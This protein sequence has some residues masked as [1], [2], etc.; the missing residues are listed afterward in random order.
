M[1]RRCGTRSIVA[2]ALVF[3]AC[4][5]AGAEPEAGA[6]TA[7][8]AHIDV[9]RTVRVLDASGEPVSFGRTGLTSEVEIDV[10]V[11]GAPGVKIEPVFAALIA[12]PGLLIDAGATPVSNTAD[13]GVATL[14]YSISASPVG[15][16]EIEV[17]GFH[18]TYDPDG[19][20]PAGSERL[21][22]EAGPTISVGELAAGVAA[23]DEPS[24]AGGAVEA[25]PSRAWVW[26]ALAALVVAVVV[27]LTI[28]GVVLLIVRRP[29]PAAAQAP[30][31]APDTVALERLDALERSGLIDRGEYERLTGE[32]SD[33]A[34]WYIGERFG[35]RAPE[36]TTQEFLS[37]ARR[38]ADL[39]GEA[40]TLSSFLRSCDE[41]KFAKATGSRE[42]A[43]SALGLVRSFVVRTRRAFGG[44]G[45]GTPPGAAQGAAQGE[46]RPDQPSAATATGGRA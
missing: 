21:F 27:G 4:G 2:A 38:N 23:A 13:S 39:G 43:E 15:V 40:D 30:R 24:E 22:V 1:L 37:A 28:V 6:T 3:G 31:R 33:I 45:E 41:L 20:G 35:L 7:S 17:P 36:M 42:E 18:V 9:E 25:L 32:A 8:D 46:A 34:R 10:V 29:A 16:G 5:V 44:A 26:L 11:S 19:P 12:G 14:A